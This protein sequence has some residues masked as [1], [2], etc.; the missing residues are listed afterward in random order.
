[1]AKEHQFNIDLKK[2]DL[3]IIRSYAYNFLKT[4]ADEIETANEYAFLLN[5][6][7][8]SILSNINEYLNNET[9]KKNEKKIS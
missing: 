3:S 8:V 1:M 6:M 4:R 7:P 5:C 9:V 2:F